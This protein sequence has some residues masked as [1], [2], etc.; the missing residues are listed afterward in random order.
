M[1]LASALLAR[2]RIIDQHPDHRKHCTARMAQDIA[3]WIVPL[4]PSGA[5]GQVR[6][7]SVRAGRK[8]DRERPQRAVAKEIALCAGHP[9]FS[10]ER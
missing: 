3:G 9:L 7:S 6:L 1:D 5:A 10:L 2:C 4:I 8:L